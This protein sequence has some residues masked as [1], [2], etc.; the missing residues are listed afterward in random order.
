M[1]SFQLSVSPHRRAAARFVDRVRR[2]LQKAYAEEPEISQTNIANAL[3]V[4]RSVIN[5]QLRGYKDITLSRVAELAWALGREPC[6]DLI[7]PAIADGANHMPTI[8]G[9]Q[10]VI[11]P[12]RIDLPIASAATTVT[13]SSAR[14]VAIRE[15][16]SAA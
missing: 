2:A 4:H 5:R 14:L 11:A 3:G 8:P 9:A 10:G 12:T 16:Q 6:F 15:L 7:V 13:G 1:T